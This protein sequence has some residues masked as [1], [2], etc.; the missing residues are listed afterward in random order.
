MKLRHITL[1]AL[2]VVAGQ[3]HALDIAT[4]NAAGTFKVYVSGASATKAIIGGLFTQ[5]CQAGTLDVYRSKTGTTAGQGDSA[6]GDSYNVYSCTMI[7]GNDFNLA[8]GTNVAFH[9]RDRGGSGYGVFPVALN[10][11]ID[12]LEVSTASCGTSPVSTTA[13]QRNWDCGNVIQRAPDGGTSDVEPALFLAEN[14]KPAAFAGD[15]FNAG[16]D[17]AV[18]RPLFSTVMGLA[19]SNP[20][21]A[22]LQTAQG[23][24]GQPSIP[25]TIASALTRVG[26]DYS[27]GWSA[28]GVANADNQLNICRRENGSGTQAAA[29]LF[30]HQ[31]PSNSGAAILAASNVDS[32]VGAVGNTAGEYFVGE[33]T[34][35]G[36]VRTCLNNASAAGAYAIGHISLENDPNASGQNWKFVRIDGAIPSRDEAKAGRYGYFVESTLQV[37]K[38][39]ATN[40]RNFL[41]RFADQ[42]GLPNNLNLL[43]AAAKNGVFATPTNSGCNVAFGTGT[44]N[45]QAF[46]GRVTRSGNN[47]NLPVIL[48]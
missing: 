36:Q 2:A 14:N 22:A 16:S 28:L 4:T 40:V 48:K 26:Y 34:S 7:A 35:S 20:L 46:C 38:A 19:V 30:F 32:S 3:A 24:T 9:K 27:L 33:G 12:F 37:N 13:T 6:A 47:Q 15:S 8:T 21:Y 39:A 10:R 41:T 25:S 23:T 11:A 44:A 5:N 18:V 29:N 45:Q 17:F 42:A 1:A 43:S 31:Y